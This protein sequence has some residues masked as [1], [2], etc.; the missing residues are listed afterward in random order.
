MF[1]IGAAVIGVSGVLFYRW[2]T[3]PSKI[4]KRKYDII[5][6]EFYKAIDFSRCRIGGSY[7]LKMLTEAE[8]EPG[9]ID[10]YVDCTG[11]PDKSRTEST[12]Y[13]IFT[14]RVKAFIKKAPGVVI[15]E[16]FKTFMEL[17][18]EHEN[19][20]MTTERFSTAIVG[21]VTLKYPGI[22]KKIQFIGIHYA[23]DYFKGFDEFLGHL[24]DVPACVVYT[25]SDGMM[26][27][28]KPKK[29]AERDTVINAS[30][31]CQ[32][33]RKKYEGRGYKFK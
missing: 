17:C 28:H 5:T 18:D 6:D 24:C 8:W 26:T 4:P 9:D 32:K 3:Q 27:F 13:E 21:T 31:I 14:D 20:D 1:K 11:P 23:T 10:I 19:D 7:A 30:W 15:G 22:N 12:S 33:R 2:Y 25:F 29:Y 16:R